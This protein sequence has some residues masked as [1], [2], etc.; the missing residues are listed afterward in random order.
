ME[1]AFTLLVNL[2]GDFQGALHNMVE[3]PSISINRIT[4]KIKSLE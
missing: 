4:R 2:S 3:R 1:N